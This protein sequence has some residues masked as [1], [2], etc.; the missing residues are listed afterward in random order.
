MKNMYFNYVLFLLI[1]VFKTNMAGFWAKQKTFGNF[2]I[3]SK[4]LKTT[5][6][7]S[8]F[9]IATAHDCLHYSGDY[10]TPPFCGNSRTRI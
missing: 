6:V 8:S 10:P 2:E 9:K 7:S 5:Q 1:A 4:I 3:I